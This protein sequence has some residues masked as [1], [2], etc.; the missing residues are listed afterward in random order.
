MVTCVELSDVIDKMYFGHL[1]IL[2]EDLVFAQKYASGAKWFPSTGTPVVS[3]VTYLVR[4]ECGLWERHQNQ[5]QCTPS[6]FDAL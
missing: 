2:L 1:N 5:L 4:T 3:S 6:D